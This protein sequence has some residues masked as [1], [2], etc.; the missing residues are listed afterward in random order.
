MNRN[1]KHKNS[2]SSGSHSDRRSPK[3]RWW[4]SAGA[5][6]LLVSVF[7]IPAKVVA[8]EE[9]QVF[10]SRYCGCCSGWVKHLEQNGFTVSV[11][12]SEDMDRIKSRLGVPENM[13]S[14]HTAVVGGYLVEGHVPADDIHKLLKNKP[15]VKGISAPGMPMGSPGMEVPGEKPDRYDVVTFDENGKTGVFSNH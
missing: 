14:C 2:T 11:E 6:A 7:I 8:A 9:I 1:H 3:F 5:I 12:E 4:I 13:E 15:K 10:K